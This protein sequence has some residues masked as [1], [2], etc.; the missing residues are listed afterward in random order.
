MSR[1]EKVGEHPMLL[2]GGK[3]PWCLS[4]EKGIDVCPKK[5]ALV[6]I[7]RKGHCCLLWDREGP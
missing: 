1:S 5:R 2:F 4:E 6:F 7:R 3:G